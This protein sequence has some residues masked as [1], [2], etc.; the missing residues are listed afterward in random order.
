MHINGIYLRF[1][2]HSQI[3][4]VL[5]LQIGDEI[6]IGHLSTTRQHQWFANGLTL[7][8]LCWQNFQARSNLA[9]HEIYNYDK[10]KEK[11]TLISIEVCWYILL[12]VVGQC[13]VL[14]STENRS[15]IQ[16]CYQIIQIERENQLDTGQSPHY[17][18]NW[19]TLLCDATF[20]FFICVYIEDTNVPVLRNRKP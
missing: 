5:P 19:H 16:C 18:M 12:F 8:Q 11:Q 17:R 9:L 20:L 4:I 7:Y 3:E 10:K 13:V 2:W 6:C 14:L 15:E 1:R